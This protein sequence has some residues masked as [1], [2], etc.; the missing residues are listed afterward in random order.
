MV[1]FYGTVLRFSEVRVQ[2]CLLHDQNLHLTLG[3]RGLEDC[4]DQHVFTA[5][6]GTI[7]SHAGIDVGHHYG[8]SMYCTWHIRAPVGYHVELVAEIFHTEGSGT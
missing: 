7:N 6:T 1:L 4:G 5:P 8:K 2:L 3:I